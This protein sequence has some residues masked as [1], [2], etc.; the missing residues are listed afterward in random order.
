MICSKDNQIVCISEATT[1]MFH[2]QG[3]RWPE[4]V[5]L[6]CG[7]K[8]GI[9][10][11]NPHIWVGFMYILWVGCLLIEVNGHYKCFHKVKEIK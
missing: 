7:E 11:R 3:P 5:N 2:E 10:A 9:V 4:A 8:N 6:E 1:W